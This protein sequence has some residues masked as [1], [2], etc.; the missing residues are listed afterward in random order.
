ME[1]FVTYDTIPDEEAA[2]HQMIRVID[3]SGEDYL[4]LKSRFVPANTP[5]ER[6]A[7]LVEQAA[8]TLNPAAYVDPLT[9][10]KVST[11]A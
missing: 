1:M 4:F 9:R 2:K 6:Y 8:E 3:E 5:V 11:H 10:R 7:E